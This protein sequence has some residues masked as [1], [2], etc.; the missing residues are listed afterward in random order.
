MQIAGARVRQSI[1]RSS[2]ERVAL[3]SQPPVLP[4]W[5]IKRRKFRHAHYKCRSHFS[6]EI[7]ALERKHKNRFTATQGFT[8][9]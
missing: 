8:D 5:E 4:Q 9:C 1:C 3:R 2:T 7:V 6:D